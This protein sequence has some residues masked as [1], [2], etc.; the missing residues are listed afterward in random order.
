M[1]VGLWARQK[2]SLESCWGSRVLGEPWTPHPH[3][4]TFVGA[5]LWRGIVCGAADGV[6]LSVFPILALCDHLPHEFLTEIAVVPC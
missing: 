2:R 6:L 3:G 5:I 4:L 1:F